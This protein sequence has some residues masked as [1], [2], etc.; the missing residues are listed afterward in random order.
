M[1]WRKRKKKVKREFICNMNK[2]PYVIVYDRYS[3]KP[4]GI[5]CGKVSR[6]RLHYIKS[7]DEFSYD[8][9]FAHGHEFSEDV[10]NCMMNPYII[11]D[12]L[13]LNNGLDLFRSILYENYGLPIHNIVN[14][15]FL[16]KEF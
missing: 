4:Y 8:C 13:P 12:V 10:T 3:H 2:R 7:K 16:F 11:P 14:K 9:R 1:N 6:I 15:P 5:F